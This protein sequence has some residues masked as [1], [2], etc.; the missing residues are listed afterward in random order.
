M[1][2]FTALWA[3]VKW[4]FSVL[5]PFVHDKVEPAIAAAIK[6]VQDEATAKAAVVNAEAA[7]KVADLIASHSVQTVQ[8]QLKA[9]LAAAEAAYNQHVSLLKAAAEARTKNATS[10]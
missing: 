5:S 7:A 4:L 10:V 9:D 1:K 6:S 2:V 3:A 8:D